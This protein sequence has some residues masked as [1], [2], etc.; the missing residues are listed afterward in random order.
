MIEILKRMIV[1]TAR[2]TGQDFFQELVLQL[3]TTLKVRHVLLTELVQ[4]TPGR[5]RVLAMA[6]GGLRAGLEYDIAAMP[7]EAVFQRKEVCYFSER[8]SFGPGA[9]HCCGFPRKETCYFAER[10]AE[11][12]PHDKELAALRPQSYLGTP[13]LD[14]AGEAIGLLC[15]IHN[16]LLPDEPL[17]QLLLSLTAERA[18]AELERR[19]TEKALRASKEY[20]ERIIDSS[21]DMIVASDCDRRL[22]VFSRAAQETFGYQASEVIGQGVELLYADAA[23]CGT[24]SAAVRSTGRFSGEI[25]NRRKNGEVFPSFL[26]AAAVRDAGNNVI[27]F[28]G[29]SRDVS[30]RRQATDALRESHRA[31]A[32]LSSAIEQTADSIIITDREG[33]IEFVNPSFEAQTGYSKGEVSGQTPRLLKSGQHPPA[34]YARVWQTLLAGQPFRGV[35]INRRKT[36]ELFH[37]EKTI[38]PIKDEDGSITHFVSAGRDVTERGRMESA[39]RESEERYRSL[40]EGSIQG[41]MVQQ[42]SIIHYVNGALCVM[43]GYETPNELVGRNIWETM[44]APE[45]RME[46]QARAAAF[47]LGEPLPAH[48]GWQALRKDGTCIWVQS[49]ASR[50]AWKGRPALLA[51]LIDV[52]EQ[53]QAEDSIRRT[54]ALYRRAITVAE[55][56][57]Y[58]RHYPT[59]TFTYLGDAVEALTGYCAAELTPQRWDSLVKDYRFLGDLTGQMWDEA[60]RKIRAREVGQWR[61][62]CLIETRAGQKRWIAD[63]S[64]E[65]FDESGQAIGSIGVLQDITERKRAEQQLYE[66]A[67][68]LDLAQDSISVR[69]LAGKIL[70]WN[71]GAEHMCGWTAAEA[72][73]EPV[74]SLRYTDTAAFDAAMREILE[75]DE[76]SG[77]MRIHSKNGHEILASCRWTLLRDPDGTPQSVLDITTDVTEKKK[78]EKQFLRAQRMESIGTLAG[79]I[80]HDLNNILAPILMAVEMLQSKLTEPG[81]QRFLSLIEASARRGSDIVKQVLTFARGVEGERVLVQ[82]KHLAKETVK[83]IRE[84]FPKNIRTVTHFAADLWTIT[85]DSTHLHQ[86]LMNLCVNARDAMPAGGTLSLAVE[87][88]H[89]DESRATMVPGAKAGPYVLLRVEDSG[90][91]IPP[92]IVDKIY[93]P[94]FTTKAPGKGTGLG[95]STVLGIVRS[96]G[97]FISVQSE[98]DAGTKFWVYLP[99]TTQG[100]ASADAEAGKDETPRGCGELILVVDDEAA[101]G[102]MAQKL[103]ERQG[104]AV[105]KAS[106]GTEAVALVAQDPGKIQLVLTDMMMPFMDGLALVRVLKRM[107]PNFK[108]IVAS[109]FG[110]GD[111]ISELTA[112]GVQSFLAKPYSAKDLL[113]AVHEALTKDRAA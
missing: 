10:V 57:P 113:N 31:L 33:V 70:F 83:M 105:W 6:N 60:V 86:V 101:I 109:G 9:G 8:R 41:V 72:A 110:E 26:V 20:L 103:L 77:E 71:K 53:K 36:G 108:V 62:D 58:V 19:R 98:M 73:E 47:L 79:G 23:E 4:N 106:D 24:V 95:L 92:E 22:T 25:R 13:L 66:Q 17:S 50:I 63:A 102:E 52:T 107:D 39:L 100:Q 28:M 54:E 99:A 27:G 42:D 82:L 55:A 91:G 104:Y 67:R 69:D 96:H 30:E 34:F 112:L 14:H 89:F 1:S 111:K 46:I 64:V 61:C 29:V 80:A 85:G 75:K 5:L 12:F 59:E 68:L 37:E 21:S 18:A 93:D 97:G 40:V 11:L 81:D 3:A 38:T 90:S 7:C 32:K 74:T 49:R 2:K 15:L 65:M 35:F 16:G 88:V 87:N 51:F 78:L 84:T 94:F 45:W 56:V 43:L 76:W 48:P 44:V